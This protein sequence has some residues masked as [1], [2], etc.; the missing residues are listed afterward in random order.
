M[1]DRV[2]VGKAPHGVAVAP[3]GKRVYVAN[4]NSGTV[5]VIDTRGEEGR[6][7]GHDFSVGTHPNGV[8]VAPDGKRHL[9]LAGTTTAVPFR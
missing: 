3:D 1:V 8:A 4:N 5:S 6:G 9:R 7:G 2:T